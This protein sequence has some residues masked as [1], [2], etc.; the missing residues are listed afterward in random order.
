MIT[1]RFKMMFATAAVFAM[2]AASFAASETFNVHTRV[3]NGFHMYSTV[4]LSSDGTV[5]GQTQ[6]KNWNNVKGFTGGVFVVALDK[7]NNAVYTTAVKSYGINA[8]F[9]KKYRTRNV[10]WTS[11]IPE[12]Y[13]VKTEKISVM[14]IH[15]PTYRVANWIKN[16]KD[17]IISHA[18][19]IA[20][21]VKS[22]KNNEFT[23]EDA[24]EIV[25]SHLK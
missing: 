22:I 6:L 19:S 21:I 3:G 16:N 18:R 20:E 1:N 17:L 25:D 24:M 23:A 9:F 14:Q 12:E 4:T 5:K 2:S 8:A 7:N 10:T 13:L 15:N 11:E